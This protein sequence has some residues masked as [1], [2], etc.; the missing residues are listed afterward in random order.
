MFPF[1][2]VLGKSALKTSTVVGLLLILSSGLLI[3]VLLSWYQFMERQGRLD[4]IVETYVDSYGQQIDRIIDLTEEGLVTF[5]YDYSWW[6]EMVD[7]ADEPSDEKWEEIGDGVLEI[8]DV[9]GAWVMDKDG[10]EVWAVNEVLPEDEVLNFP[11]APYELKRAF[12]N[13]PYPVFFVRDEKNIIQIAGAPIQGG[14]DDERTS[15]P[16]GYLLGMRYW[17]EEH[18]AFLS[19]TLGAEIEIMNSGRNGM[20]SIADILAEE[21]AEATQYR[22]RRDFRDRPVVTFRII[23]P[24][25]GMQEARS[26]ISWHSSGVFGGLL[27]FCVLFIAIVLFT[28]IVPLK[29][30][31]RALDSENEDE[32]AAVK[33]PGREWD[34][35]AKL[36]IQSIRQRK[37]LVREIAQRREAEEALVESEMKLRASIDERERIARD[38]HDGVIQS[39]YATGLQLES[40]R[41]GL[42][43][44]P[45]KVPPILANVKNS[46][47]SLI[48]DIRGF[49]MGLAPK[50]LVEVGF[51]GSVE[52]MLESLRAADI[53]VE[54]EIDQHALTS[55]NE[56]ERLN[57]FFVI[58]ELI[59]NI[60]RHSD[61]NEVQV[62]LSKTE[63][64]VKLII[65]DNG[66]WNESSPSFGEG[67]GL[68]NIRDR[69]DT[70]SARFSIGLDEHGWIRALFIIPQT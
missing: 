4:S 62:T 26:I 15:E 66:H 19:E 27:L 61:A 21:H 64:S 35:L 30:L 24:I 48:S 2:V 63:K 52:R 67:N 47:N 10:R 44:D 69:A 40:A 28:V 41:L 29:R 59:S 42:K 51:Q 1:D 8:F 46:L 50:D 38:L 53:K 56:K 9:D 31:S 57:L 23:H 11:L 70:I 37:D 20:P 45:N 39:A 3:L 68:K 5:V 17:D 6:D 34:N 33:L 7:F 14:D 25:P 16:A 13:N 54:S 43:E 22:T 18:I 12:R 32:L 58:Q 49:I 55:L 65:R 60:A 36:I